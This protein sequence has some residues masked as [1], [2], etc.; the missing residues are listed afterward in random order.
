[1]LKNVRIYLRILKKNP[2]F[3][4]KFI[5]PKIASLTSCCILDEKKSFLYH[6]N[7]LFVPEGMPLMPRTDILLN[8]H[9]TYAQDR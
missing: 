5:F 6:N 7:A 8:G 1:M 9:A 2:L 3:F 4:F